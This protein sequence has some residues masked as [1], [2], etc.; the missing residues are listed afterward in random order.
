MY[1][2]RCGTLNADDASYCKNCGAQIQV[3]NAN[4]IPQAPAQAPYYSPPR[5][6]PG[7][8]ATVA[9]VLNLFFGLGYWYLGYR[10]V[11]SVPTTVFVVVAL[12]VYIVVSLFTAGIVTLLLAILL[13]IDGY[14]KGEG[15]RGFVPA[16]M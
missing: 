6:I 4:T 12:I 10:K 5:A 1:C 7:K 11:L 15:K 9:A 16:E 8:N 13:A 2:P 14:Q 3:E